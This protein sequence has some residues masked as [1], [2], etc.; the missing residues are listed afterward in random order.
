MQRI[1]LFATAA[2]DERIARLQA[3]DCLAV[4]HSTD[5]LRLDVALCP[6]RPAFAFADRHQLGVAPRTR[7]DR[8]RHEIVMQDRI[9]L[10]QQPG[11]AQGEKIWVARAGAH[12]VG[13]ASDGR[14]AAC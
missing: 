1:D 7:E 6:A 12:D 5:H 9:G 13:N 2:E 14:S 10:L 3:H 11:G 8:R 4:S